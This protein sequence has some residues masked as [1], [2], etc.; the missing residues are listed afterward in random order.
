MSIRLT[1]DAV[2]FIGMKLS[3]A[4]PV[5]ADEVVSTFAKCYTYNEVFLL[6]WFRYQGAG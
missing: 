5:D 4:V 6:T 2:H 3:D 1:I